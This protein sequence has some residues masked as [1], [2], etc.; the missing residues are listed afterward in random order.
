MPRSRCRS[1]KGKT[2]KKSSPRRLS[3]SSR[4]KTRA[5]YRAAA[6]HMD[7]AKARWFYQIVG[8]ETVLPRYHEEALNQWLR[9]NEDHDPGNYM[10]EYGKQLLG[11]QIYDTCGKRYFIE[12][13]MFDQ[14][15]LDYIYDDLEKKYKE[16]IERML[17][18]MQTGEVMLYVYVYQEGY[19]AGGAQMFAARGFRPVRL[20]SDDTNDEHIQMAMQEL[21]RS[22][23]LLQC[24][25][26]D[27]PMDKGSGSGKRR[28]HE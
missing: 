11:H 27:A 8:S 10:A 13:G 17:P 7:S 24:D 23:P 6:T 25:D 14:G 19:I 3:S 15:L 21:I 2:R 12:Y 16:R 4:G 9:S 28:R 5:R 1:S 18:P 22:C 26:N 20:R